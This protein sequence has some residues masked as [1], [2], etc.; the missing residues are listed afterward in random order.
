[1]YSTF[2]VNGESCLICSSGELGKLQG[3]FGADVDF[4]NNRVVVNH[5][6][7]VSREDMAEKLRKLGFLE[8]KDNCEL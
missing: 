1:M 3:V 2:D 6:D 5:T 7:E 4:I 8:T